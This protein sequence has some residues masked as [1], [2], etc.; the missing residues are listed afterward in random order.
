MN[1]TLTSPAL[2]ASLADLQKRVC[3]TNQDIHRHQLA[4]LTW[5]NA[6]E[7]DREAGV[8]AI[9]PSGVDYDDL[10]PA[11]SEHRTGVGTV[12]IPSA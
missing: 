11:R 3:K 5:G 1:T 12:R 6:S 8:F 2:S 4:I 9:K 7:I 10:R